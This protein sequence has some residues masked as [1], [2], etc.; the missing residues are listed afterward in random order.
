MYVFSHT[1]PP[2]TRDEIREWLTDWICAFS[3]PPRRHG[4]YIC[5]TE[6]GFG[7]TGYIVYLNVETL[8]FVWKLQYREETDP[9][10]MDPST[11]PHFNSL[12]EMMDYAVEVTSKIWDVK[13]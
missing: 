5:I 11:E 12:S 7:V 9:A 6:F 2:K 13:E 4:Q 1:N 8:K 3:N 10:K